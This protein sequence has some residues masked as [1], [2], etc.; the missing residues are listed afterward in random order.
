M[1]LASDLDADWVNAASLW[2]LRNALA[3]HGMRGLR[4][5]L[6]L[7]ADPRRY[8]AHPGEISYLADDDALVRS[9]ISAAGAYGLDLVPGAEIDAYV[10]ARDVKRVEQEHALVPAERGEANAVVRVVRDSAWHLDQVGS[11]APIAAVALDLAEDPD[12]RSARAGRD[13]LRDLNR[14]VRR[15]LR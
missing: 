12:P 15:R 7:R 2:R 5:R 8:R 6:R 14:A 4:P 10:A 1:F 9:G 11:V 13:A 3:L